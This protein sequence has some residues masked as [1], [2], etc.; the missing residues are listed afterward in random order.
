[1]NDFSHARVLIVDDDPG[2]SALTA[3]LLHRFGVRCVATAENGE[4]ALERLR[5]STLNIQVVFTDKSMPTMDGL[6][7]ILRIRHEPILSHVKVAMISGELSRQ[8]DQSDAEIALR[9]F[10]LDKSVLPIPR[11]GLDTDVIGHALMTLL[12]E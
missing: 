8:G 2:S 6:D 11:D 5:D 12:H 4:Q 3:A 10:L 9:A 7:L 1:M